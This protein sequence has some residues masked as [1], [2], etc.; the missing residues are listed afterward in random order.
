MRPCLGRPGLLV[1]NCNHPEYEECK[2]AAS[3][4]VSDNYDGEI[5]TIIIDMIFIF[6]SWNIRSDPPHNHQNIMSLTEH[7]LPALYAGCCYVVWYWL[8]PQVLLFVQSSPQLAPEMLRGA[9]ALHAICRSIIVNTNIKHWSPFSTLS[10]HVDTGGLTHLGQPITAH[11]PTMW[12]VTHHQPLIGHL[13]SLQAP[14]W[15][16][17]SLVYCCAVSLRLT[18]FAWKTRTFLSPFLTARV[19]ISRS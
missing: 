16:N 15:L 6:M 13:I 1:E 7:R 10:G 3:L 12:H 11:S 9:P 17:M 14:D 2:N 5:C 19:F 4:R 18:V 8:S